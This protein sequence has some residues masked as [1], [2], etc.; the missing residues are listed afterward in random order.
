MNNR[1]KSGGKLTNMRAQVPIAIYLTN[2]NRVY[3]VNIGADPWAML[4]YEI[5][6]KTYSKSTRPSVHLLCNVWQ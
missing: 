3:M 2:V 5:N 1:M 6:G 4:S